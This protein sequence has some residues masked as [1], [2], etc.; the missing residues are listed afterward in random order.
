MKRLFVYTMASLFSI[1]IFAQSESV[2]ENP[3]SLE[4]YFPSAVSPFTA[5]QFDLK[6][7][8]GVS[9]VEKETD[10]SG[11]VLEASLNASRKND[12]V[13]RVEKISDRTYRFLV[14]SPTN[15]NITVSDEVLLTAQVLCDADGI[16]TK[17]DPND[18]LSNV[19]FVTAEGEDVTGPL[20]DSQLLISTAIKGVKY[21]SVDGERWYRLNGQRV[22]KPSKGFYIRNREKIL[23]K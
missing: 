20:G 23:V 18:G 3:N 8:E 2:T 13:L 7:P 1:G 22:E 11:N 5:F 6:L 9:M 19:L 14:F 4:I 12:H 10:S 16:G 21:S 15:A 17:V